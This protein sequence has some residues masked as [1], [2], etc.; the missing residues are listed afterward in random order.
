MAERLNLPSAFSKW[1][2]MK[3]EFEKSDVI[4]GTENCLLM[5]IN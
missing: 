1:E 5:N 3:K 4:Q 2:K